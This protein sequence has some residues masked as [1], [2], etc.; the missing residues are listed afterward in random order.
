NE[1]RLQPAPHSCRAGRLLLELMQNISQPLRISL[2]PIELGRALHGI[3]K[4]TEGK[5]L[6]VRLNEKPVG[7]STLPRVEMTIARHGA[8]GTRESGQIP[9]RWSVHRLRWLGQ[10]GNSV[11]QGAADILGAGDQ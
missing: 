2:S 11:A 5:T 7:Q 1:P 3:C 8:T 9:R 10:E 6:F 4:Q